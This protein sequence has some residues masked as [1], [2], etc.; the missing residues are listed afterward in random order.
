[1]ELFDPWWRG[2][3]ERMGLGKDQIDAYAD[4]L[5]A[6]KV[7]IRPCLFDF[8]IETDN[9][10]TPEISNHTPEIGKKRKRR[11]EE[12]EDYSPN[13]GLPEARVK[14]RGG[15]SAGGPSTSTARGGA[16]MVDRA[17]EG[18]DRDRQARAKAQAEAEAGAEDGSNA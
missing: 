14:A 17:I 9:D 18:F 6:E 2:A 3:G 10:H 7:V 16:G 5:H 12:D 15:R 13:K 4:Y 1:M 8:T 11:A